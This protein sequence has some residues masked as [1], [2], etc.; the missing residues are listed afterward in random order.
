M[1]ILGRSEWINLILTASSSGPD[2][3]QAGIENA[4]STSRGI[5]YRW[6]TDSTGGPALD[7]TVV[8]PGTRW[9][10]V[11]SV[12]WRLQQGGVV[13]HDFL[14]LDVL[15]DAIDEWLDEALTMWTNPCKS[16]RRKAAT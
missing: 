14:P 16:S 9:G 5:D 6:V 2:P 7:I 11:F 13:A 12:L 8:N 1:W 4:L 3:E 10:A 15:G